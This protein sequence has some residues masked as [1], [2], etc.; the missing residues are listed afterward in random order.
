MWG[1]NRGK[2]EVS[3]LIIDNDNNYKIGGVELEVENVKKKEN[4]REMGTQFQSP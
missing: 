1:F 4:G 3:R 2:N